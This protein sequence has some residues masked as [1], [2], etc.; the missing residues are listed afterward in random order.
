MEGH[1][2]RSDAASRVF[3][4]GGANASLNFDALLWNDKNLAAGHR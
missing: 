3:M 2:G 4:R 1:P